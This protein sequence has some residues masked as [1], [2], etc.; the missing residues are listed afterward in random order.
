MNRPSRRAASSWLA[1]VLCGMLLSAALMVAVVP[2]RRIRPVAQASSTAGVETVPDGAAT[3]VTTTTSAGGA[4]ATAAVAS[5]RPVLPGSASVAGNTLACDAE[6]NGGA[7]DV[8]VTA[9]SIRLGATVVDSG[10]GA[11]F[12]HDARYG[13]LAV[14]N[15][16]NEQGGICGRKLEIELK[17]DGWDPGRG[18]DY[19]KSLV[20]D[21]RVFALSVVP[22][23]EGL[24]VV[25]ESGYLQQKRIPTVGTDGMLKHQYS[26]PQIWPVAAST[27]STMH[28]AAKHAHDGPL[29]ATKF[30]IV[31]EFTYHFGR[32]GA[33][34]FNAAV[35]RLTGTDIAG[36]TAGNVCQARFCG[37][38]ATAGDYSTQIQTFNNACKDCD[39][40]VLLLEPTTALKWIQQ[41]GLVLAG[42]HTAGPQPLFTADF[43]QECKARCHG[44]WLWTGY[45]PAIGANLGRPAVAAYRDDI[46]AADSSADYT[47]T[48]VEG[49]YAGMQLLVEA[50]RRAGPNLTR[51]ALS[52]TLDSLDIDTGLTAS[53]LAWRPGRHFA[54]ASMQAYSIQYTDRFSGWRD[55]QVSL[56][57]PWLGQD[58]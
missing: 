35:R 4:V 13:I 1:G 15:K 32:E 48:F 25:S 16:V 7:T 44:M 10:V 42:G 34:A 19:I 40:M 49:A 8:G 51:A 43:A 29:H 30:G 22:S 17:D 27:V 21:E 37:I 39:F 41:N 24:R 14:K 12:L 9:T 6:H 57:D 47:N 31:Y 36:Y 5:K 38:D 23:S 33:D 18:S 54:N 28:I 56:A 53:P 3:E 26:D 45:V 46:R 58:S 11:A 55:E 2:P 20:E 52:R 50:I